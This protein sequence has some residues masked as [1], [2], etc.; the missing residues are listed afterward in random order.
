MSLYNQ[1]QTNSKTLLCS[2]W[3]TI[4]VNS[5]DDQELGMAQEVKSPENQPQFSQTLMGQYWLGKTK[6]KPT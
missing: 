1:H 3:T 6:P 2:S 5:R 4:V